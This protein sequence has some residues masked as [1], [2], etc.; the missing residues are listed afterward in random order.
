[1]VRTKHE[2]SGAHLGAFL[3]HAWFTSSFR[4]VLRERG[5]ACRQAGSQAARLA[6]AQAGLDHALVE[7]TLGSQVVAVLEEGFSLY[8]VLFGFCLKPFK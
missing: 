4:P 5:S 7:G 6:G 2:D 3:A 8:Y 1:M